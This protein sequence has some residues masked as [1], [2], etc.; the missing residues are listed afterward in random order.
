MFRKAAEEDLPAICELE[1]SWSEEP[2]SMQAL[3]DFFQAPASRILV[4]EEAGEICGY[5]TL[6]TA[7]DYG[8]IAN[9]AVDLRLRRRGIGKALLAAACAYA[10]EAGASC[11]TLEVRESNTA[12]RALYESLGGTVC[13]RRR[14]FY[15]SPAEDA[16][17]YT[18]STL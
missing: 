14:G 2:W 7:G 3:T 9:L 15:R 12:A 17:V 11:L 5:V 16:L 18:L 4:W 8:E 13:G 10:C 6:R 1:K